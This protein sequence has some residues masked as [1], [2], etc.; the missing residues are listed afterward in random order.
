[1]IVLKTNYL[2][3]ASPYNFKRL[4]DLT[5]KIGDVSIKPSETIRNLS[6]FFYIHMNMS[7]HNYKTALVA[8]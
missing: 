5:L 2:V 1:M 8:L 4:P 3:A 7:A 6:A